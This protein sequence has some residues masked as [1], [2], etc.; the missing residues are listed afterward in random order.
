VGHRL[1]RPAVRTS[2]RRPTQRGWT[3]DVAARASRLRLLSDEY[4][5]IGRE[6]AHS[7]GRWSGAFGAHS[8]RSRPGAEK[9]SPA[10]PRCGRNGLTARECSA[11][12]H[13]R[14]APR[15]PQPGAH[16]AAS[17]PDHPLPERWGSPA[18]LEVPARCPTLSRTPFGDDRR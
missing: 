10:G 16:V 17:Q 1:C 11:T 14:G 2:L 13:C 18:S 15:R 12:S 7:W 9:G 3:T 4:G 8:T 5:L 6:R